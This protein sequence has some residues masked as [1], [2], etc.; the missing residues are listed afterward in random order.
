MNTC[1]I[2]VALLSVPSLGPAKLGPAPASEAFDEQIQ[3]R[4]DEGLVG[5]EQTGT[6]LRPA[7]DVAVV[8]DRPPDGV[9]MDAERAD[10]GAD[11]PKLGVEEAANLGV[12]LGRDHGA[13]SS[14]PD[15]AGP[16]P[17]MGQGLVT[18]EAPATATAGAAKLRRSTLSMGP[19]LVI[20]WDGRRL[21][22]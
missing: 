7:A 15:A 19:L 6:N 20:A 11:A 9:G 18:H 10:D 3:G 16:R 4:G 5:I 2:V 21:G 22:R 1:T 8:L 14:P 12:L 17:E 13:T